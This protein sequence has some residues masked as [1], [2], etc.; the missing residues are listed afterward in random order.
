MVSLW[1]R[2]RLHVHLIFI[3][4]IWGCPSSTVRYPRTLFVDGRRSIDWS[5][6]EA[7]AAQGHGKEGILGLGLKMAKA[8]S[9]LQKRDM[10][11]ETYTFLIQPLPLGSLSIVRCGEDEAKVVLVL[12]INGPIHVSLPL[13]PIQTPL[14]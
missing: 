6:V 3:A 8:M 10:L 12:F 13:D 7:A 1:R 4:R 5:V 11:K 14:L 2:A 9:A